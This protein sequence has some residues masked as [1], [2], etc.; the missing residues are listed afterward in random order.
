MKVLFCD[1]DD[2]I[3]FLICVLNTYSF[4]LMSKSVCLFVCW[5]GIAST[6]V[7]MPEPSDFVD[8]SLTPGKDQCIS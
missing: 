8:R 6:K 7:G 3:C 4:H 5:F 1:S 2:K